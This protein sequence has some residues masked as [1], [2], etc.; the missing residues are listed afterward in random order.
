MSK[1]IPNLNTPADIF[2][3]LIIE[4]LKVE[5]IKGN[6]GDI[7]KVS[8]AEECVRALKTELTKLIAETS[9]DLSELADMFDNLV[10]AVSTVS[11]CE[12]SKADLHKLNPKPHSAISSIDHVSRKANEDRAKYKRAINNLFEKLGVANSIHEDRTF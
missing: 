11:F 6:S 9:G 3:R 8:S 12:N 2:D 5:H 7:N 10:V 4:R 1:R